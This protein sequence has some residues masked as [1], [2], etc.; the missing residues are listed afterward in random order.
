MTA[1]VAA[2]SDIVIIGSGA[3]GLAGALTAC[4]R[5]A[6]VTVLE[7]SPLIGGTTAMS[8]GLLWVP[9]NPKGGEIGF[10]D[11]RD[12]VIEYICTA[13]GGPPD[14]ALVEA[15]VDHAAATISFLES[16]SPLVTINT[17]YP[18]TFVELPGGVPAG[19]HLEPA[20]YSLRK[21]GAWRRKLRPASSLNPLTTRELLE[22]G[23]VGQLRA[24]IKKNLFRIVWRM[25]RAERAGGIA[26]AGALLEGCI[27]RGVRFDLNTRATQL[28]LDNSGRVAGV[29]VETERGQQRFVAHKGVLLAN[30]GF[31]WNEAMVQRY[32][33]RTLAQLPSAP[34]LATGD[35]VR[36][37]QQAGAALAHMDLYWGWPTAEQP[38]L[39]YDEQSI[40]MLMLGERTLPHCL[41]VNGKGQRFCNEAEHNV[42]FALEAR[43][44]RGALANDPAWAIVDGQYRSKYP[45]LLKLM[46]GSKDP[47]WLIKE[48][49]LG[50][51]AVRIGVDPAQLTATVTRFNAMASNGRDEDFARGAHG[52][53]RA[54]GD[55]TA[56]HPN[57]G[58][59]TTPPFYA[60]R[61]HASAVGTRGGPSIDARGRVQSTSGGTV[62]GLYAAGNAAACF[63]GPRFIGGGA[64]IM[65][66]MTFARLA[67]LTAL[68]SVPGN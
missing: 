7:R 32:L 17:P 15:F 42:A 46:P 26:L 51:L 5:G 28:L 65:P 23:F 11:S 10:S 29:I 4:E 25:M 2:A 19:R 34:G 48:S 67:M 64:T 50:Q 49:T 45:L 20:P 56:P 38:G 62:P 53:E 14:R 68:E 36:L 47:E 52:Y 44:R 55:P 31:E 39:R 22:G 35:N 30:G 12:R 6:S 57:L 58:P 33:P 24:I 66:A 8:G 3:A 27:A 40:G 63:Y 60:V 59:L 13:M 18:D 9:M 41:W 1:S 54:L 37:A 21:L 16:A 43:D 61:V